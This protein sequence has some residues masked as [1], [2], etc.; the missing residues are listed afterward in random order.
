MKKGQYFS[1]DAIVASILFILALSTFLGYWWGLKDGLATN[2]IFLVQE[3]NH[4]SQTF[5]TKFVI[6]GVANQTMITTLNKAQSDGTLSKLLMANHKFTLV[7]KY[8][9]VVRVYG[10]KAVHARETYVLERV[11]PMIK[12]GKAEM[13][14]M[15]IRVYG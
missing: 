10:E 13:V 7:L 4:I 15:D 12:D 11:F 9:G 14:V 8:G 3:A 5:F 2:H 6:G 1:M